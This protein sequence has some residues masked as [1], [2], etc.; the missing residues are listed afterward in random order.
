MPTLPAL[1]ALDAKQQ[2]AASEGVVFAV[3]APFGTDEV[4]STYPGTKRVPIERQ[5]LVR[6]LQKVAGMGV[7]VVAL[8]DLYDDDTYV[9]EIPA[10]APQQMQIT[11]SWK[12]DMASPRA[13]AGFL[14]HV[15]ARHPCAALVLALEGHGA[16]FLPEIDLNRIT[17]AAA[18]GSGQY[19]WQLGGDGAQVVPAPNS[20][21][22]P[23]ISPVLPVISP[24]LP[25]TRLPIS[26]WGLG[27]AL[28]QAQ[29][30]GAQRPAVIH[31][32]NCFNMSVELLHTVAPH[33]DYA[34]GY[35]NYNFF[36]AGSAYPRVFR[37]LRQSRRPVTADMLAKWFAAENAVGLRAKGN[38]PTVGA[39]IRLAD[40][41]KLS[42]AIDRLADELL[43]L[44]AGA[45]RRAQRDLI[46]AAAMA[47]QQYDTEGDYKLD[48]PDQITDLGGFATQ[49]Q[50]RFAPNTGVNVAA[51]KVLDALRGVWQYGDFERPWPDENQI[52]DFRDSRLGVGI[53]FPDPAL[54]G[55][56]DWRTPYYLSG[57][58]DP[59][60]PPA[61]RAVIPFL[62]DR[63]TGSPPWVRFI[64]EYHRGEP[65]RGFLRARAPEFPKFNATFERKLPPPSDKDQGPD[66][67]G[68]QQQGA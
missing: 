4:L 6:A 5:A 42:K 40:M 53:L 55:N 25:A 13:L 39:T 64:V 27:W 46:Q 37:R 1:H 60:K 33:A 24:V 10:G 45:D 38:H 17:A 21:A 52:W 19:Q 20:P 68:S 66:G 67:G 35:A 30:A 26:T 43:T 29:K 62:A 8:I 15:H 44:L 36:T 18:S 49:L 14:R 34:T 47:A 57:K 51:G 56:F 65:F 32:D 28:A 7:H 41:G 2:S 58:V 31:F 61:H 54:Q 48:P 22:L 59:A 50:A 3:Y 16:G 63:A 9:V 12:E 23:V 11:S